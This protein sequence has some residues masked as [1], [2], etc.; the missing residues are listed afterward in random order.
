M[1]ALEQKKNTSLS[2]IL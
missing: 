2:F 1:K